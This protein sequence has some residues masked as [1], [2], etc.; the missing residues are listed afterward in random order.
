MNNRVNRLVLQQALKLLKKSKERPVFIV[1]AGRSGS[2]YLR[3]M[4]TGSGKINIPP[5]SGGILPDSFKTYI[6]S[7]GWEQKVQNVIGAFVSNSE[8]EY[9]KLNQSQIE[10]HVETRNKRPLGDLIAEIYNVYGKVHGNNVNRWGDKTPFLIYYLKELQTIFPGAQF[11]HLVRNPVDVINS[12]VEHFNESIEKATMR[13]KSSVGS[14]K[15]HTNKFNF[16]EIRYEDMVSSDS[17]IQ[18][19]FDFLN[20]GKFDPAF[21]KAKLNLGDTNLS[22]HARINDA[23]RKTEFKLSETEIQWIQT[24]LQKELQYYGY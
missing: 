24:K 19:V 8:F 3:K 1:S 10:S 18:K 21:K 23:S 12:R 14:A 16:L 20:L 6:I 13:W 5:E 4:L 15:K 9:W 7:N 22:H 11:I 17:D 2:T